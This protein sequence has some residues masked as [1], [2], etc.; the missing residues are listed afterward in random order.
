M[1]QPTHFGLSLFLLGCSTS[2]S[3]TRVGSD[4]VVDGVPL[5]LPVANF[6]IAETPASAD[7]PTT[8]T[9]SL[10][11]APSADELYSVKLKPGSMSSSDLKLAFGAQGQLTGL[12]ASL[13]PVTA[14]TIRALGDFVVAGVG[15]GARAAVTGMADSSDGGGPGLLAE[16]E[17]TRKK[18]EEVCPL[19]SDLRHV[20]EEVQAGRAKAPAYVTVLNSCKKSVPDL[21][22]PMLSRLNPDLDLAANF[23]RLYPTN[24]TQRAALEATAAR[25]KTYR[26]HHLG[27]AEESYA[28]RSV[29]SPE[30]EQIEA[31][32]TALSKHAV[33]LVRPEKGNVDG[34]AK[35]ARAKALAI[36]TIDERNLAKPLAEAAK[37]S[38][39]EWRNRHATAVED[40]I[41]ALGRELALETE[42]DPRKLALREQLQREWAVTV[43]GLAEFERA[44]ILRKL[45]LRTPAKIAD[46]VIVRAELDGLAT[47][48]AQR[49]QALR[50][51]MVATLKARP[52][53]IR[54]VPELYDGA[55][56]S[57][58]AWVAERAKALGNPEFIVVVEHGVQP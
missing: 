15:V 56:P 6:V 45:L 7:K 51:A 21:L 52:R 5:R 30:V 48:L 41:E 40:R 29:K 26:H 34:L 16:L 8:Y 46:Y 11:Q 42:L 58:T 18:P 57:T 2:V 44:A 23:A 32:I 24:E 55:G 33:V 4:G 28:G 53:E 25:V 10:V 12:N 22:E 9:L 20:Q 37:L 1:N 43:D 27:M 14:P 31:A 38:A 17:E 49:R 54:V 47:T 36:V 39:R 35:L 13:S 19:R 50:P 3:A